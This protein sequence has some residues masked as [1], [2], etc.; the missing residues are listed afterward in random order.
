MNPE[1]LW[2]ELERQKANDVQYQQ[3]LGMVKRLEPGY[4]AVLAML[5]QEQ[6]QQVEDYVGACEA[7]DDPLVYIAFRLGQEK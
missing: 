4:L 3:L 6:R 7:L 2:N 5:S 1:E